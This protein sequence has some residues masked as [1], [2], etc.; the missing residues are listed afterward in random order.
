MEQYVV[1]ILSIHNVTHNVRAYRM[2]KPSGYGFEPGQ[3]T[4]VSINKEGWREEKPIIRVLR[5]SSIN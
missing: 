4:D 3:A 2:E 5:I 1:K